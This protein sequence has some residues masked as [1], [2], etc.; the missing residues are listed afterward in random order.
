MRR[1]GNMQLTYS[2]YESYGVQVDEFRQPTRQVRYDLPLRVESIL[3]AFR[4]KNVNSSAVLC[5][6]F[7]TRSRLYLGVQWL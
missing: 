2:E 4:P 6:S 7:S 5:H 1:P 3:S